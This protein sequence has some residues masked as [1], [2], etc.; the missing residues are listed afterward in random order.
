MSAGGGVVWGAGGSHECFTSTGGDS[1]E[2]PSS[3][4]SILLATGYAQKGD[5][6]G[7]KVMTGESKDGGTGSINATVRRSATGLGGSIGLRAGS[8]PASFKNFGAPDAVVLGMR[9][10]LARFLSPTV[11]CRR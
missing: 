7:I 4:G 11:F 9:P 10:L 1:M 6:G 5:S 3:S 2:H 8:Q